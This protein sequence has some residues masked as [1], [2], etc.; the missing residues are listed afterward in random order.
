MYAM[1]KEKQLDAMQAVC[2]ELGAE[3]NYRPEYGHFTAMIW[4]DQDPSCD[5]GHARSI[6]NQIQQRT[7]QYPNLVCY[8][9]D[10][11]STLVYAI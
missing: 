1:N 2:R 4:E 7:A 11:Y 8:C 9:F 3:V 5:E 10:P 6:Q